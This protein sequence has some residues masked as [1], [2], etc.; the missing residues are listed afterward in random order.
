LFAIDG[1]AYRG[2]GR[3]NNRGDLFV[4]H[5]GSGRI[6]DRTMDSG[7]SAYRGTGRIAPYSL[8]SPEFV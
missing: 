5:R 7:S 2:T 1:I 6:E 8:P 3:F 4:S